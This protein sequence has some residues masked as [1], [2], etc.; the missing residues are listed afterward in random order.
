MDGKACARIPAPASAETV[1]A[2]LTPYPKPLLILETSTVKN[3]IPHVR[4]FSFPE[5]KIGHHNIHHNIVYKSEHQNKKRRAKK[6]IS[7][8]QQKIR[9]MDMP[10]P[11][12]NLKHRICCIYW[13]RE[14][15]DML[16]V[17][18]E[19]FRTL[20]TCLGGIT[21][22]IFPVGQHILPIPRNIFSQTN[23]K[24]R[25]HHRRERTPHPP[26]PSEN[27]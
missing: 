12:H 11:L 20:T 4:K 6:L 23:T 19:T 27:I 21:L 22:N 3:S 14:T 15:I 16:G 5:V 17:Y 7:V 8:H 9:D 26:I 2:V 13:L 25:P 18:P 10:G 1:S 24:P